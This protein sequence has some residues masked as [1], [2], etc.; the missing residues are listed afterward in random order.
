M[1]TIS[2]LYEL[3]VEG[4]LARLPLPSELQGATFNQLAELPASHLAVLFTDRGAFELD[5][6]GRLS[7]IAQLDSY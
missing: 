1:V 7:R 3:T 6:A 5:L 4:H 2:G